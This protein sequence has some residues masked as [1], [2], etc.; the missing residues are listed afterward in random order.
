MNLD[1]L[2]KEQSSEYD[3]SLLLFLNYGM[4]FQFVLTPNSI[5]SKLKWEFEDILINSISNL[6]QS[7]FQMKV[8]FSVCNCC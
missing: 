3:L 5:D 4:S 8:W 2:K 6:Y 1:S 7:L